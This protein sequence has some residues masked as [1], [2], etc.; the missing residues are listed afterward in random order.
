M[1]T[2]GGA[3]RIL[4]LDRPATL[5]AV[6]EDLHAALLAALR[7]VAADE[8]VRAVVLTGSGR[9]FSAGGDLDLIRAMGDDVGLRR[10]VL[11]QGRDIFHLLTTLSV[12]VVAAING[13]A[14]GAGC[15]LALLCDI[16]VMAE[17]TH[18]ADPHVALGLVPGDGGAVLW[19][20]VAGLAAAR[21]YLLTGDR[22]PAQ[23]A[24]RLG[25]VHRIVPRPDVLAV[26]IAL[27]ERIAALPAFA[28]RETK[29]CLDAYVAAAARVVFE[30][31]LA[32]E[33]RSFDTDEHRAAVEALGR[34]K[35]ST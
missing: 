15:T 16:V 34:R 2:D 1:R 13:P 23:E 10:D 22:L 14:V 12:P 33:D 11:G 25:L 30:R 19:P 5:N 28:V 31:A 26:A 18:L 29:R 20:L 35:D 7:A 32:G 4:T 27:A 8:E 21:A 6:D 9:A 17:D 24:H 3:V